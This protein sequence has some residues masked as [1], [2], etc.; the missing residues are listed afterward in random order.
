MLTD[1]KMV[2]W[3][4]AT[5][6]KGVTRLT[7]EKILSCDGKDG[8]A[9]ETSAAANTILGEG[10]APEPNSLPC[11]LSPCIDSDAAAVAVK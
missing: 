11:G 10:T 2:G 7:R 3:E 1:Q 4:P 5:V 6:V 9:A 8:F